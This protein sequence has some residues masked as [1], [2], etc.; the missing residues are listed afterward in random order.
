M[1][2]QEIDTSERSAVAEWGRADAVFVDHR[3]LQ[4]GPPPSYD[5]IY[6]AIER[7]VKKLR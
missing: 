7:R 2:F 1:I 6:K 4:Q 5:K 3:P